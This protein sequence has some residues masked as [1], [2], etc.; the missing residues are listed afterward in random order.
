VCTIETDQI[1]PAPKRRETEDILEK[2]K[3]PYQLNL[4]SDVEHGF[5]VRCDISQK[6]QKFAKE[7][8]FFQ[9][10]AWFDEYVKSE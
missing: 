1:F 2:L 9:A 3:V 4:F 10:V 5:A 8:A 6:R 7:Q